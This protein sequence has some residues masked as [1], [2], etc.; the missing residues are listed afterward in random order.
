MSDRAL[1]DCC[2][3]DAGLPIHRWPFKF[4]IR[5][6]LTECL[7]SWCRL[8]ICLFVCGDGAL[9]C[10][11][12]TAQR[13][14]G[15]A[16]YVRVEL[17]KLMLHVDQTEQ[18]GSSCLRPDSFYAQAVELWLRS[19]WRPPRW[20][21]DFCV[22]PFWGSGLSAVS[23]AHPGPLPPC[24]LHV[25]SKYLLIW[26][27]F[28]VSPTRVHSHG[29]RDDH[30]LVSCHI[31]RGTVTREHAKQTVWGDTSS[32]H[33]SE[34]THC[35]PPWIIQLLLLGWGE[36]ECVLLC[37]PIHFPYRVTTDRESNF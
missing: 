21:S 12:C 14:T 36:R 30:C 26:D 31:S 19:W 35:L 11:Q 37:N 5:V 2:T 4:I 22:S 1:Q 8:F 13:S 15:R 6:I 25:E 27:P 33:T 32:V 9:R 18:Y 7:T 29:S 23:L 10:P 16:G 20:P 17:G 34:T 28:H 3:E 24:L